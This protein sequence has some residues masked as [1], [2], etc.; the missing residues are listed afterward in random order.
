MK[1]KS[2][3]LENFAAIYV[4]LRR[5]RLKL[6]FSTFPNIIT[7]IVG[8]MGSGKT[9]ILS[10][11]HPWA[12]IGTLDE[13]NSDQLIRPE[14]DGLK[15][16]VFEDAGDIYDITHKYTWTKDHHATKSFFKFNGEELNPNGNQSSFKE[17]VTKFM[18]VD[19]SY[20]R[21][22]RIGPNVSNIIDMPWNQR[23]LY[24]ADM[25]QS[26]DIYS[27]ILA[28]VKQKMRSCDAELSVITKQMM[29]VTD[30]DID[31][32][33]AT[34]DR[35]TKDVECEEDRIV[36]ISEQIQ[37]LIATNDTMLRKHQVMSLDQ[38]KEIKDS[39]VDKRKKANDDIDEVKAKIARCDNSLNIR[40][41]MKDIGKANANI[42]NDKR[43]RLSLERQSDEYTS[44]LNSLKIKK[45]NAASDSYIKSLA[46]TYDSM[47][48][49][50]NEY[51]EHLKDY[52]YSMTSTEITT[53]MSDIQLMDQLIF[54]V[55]CC[56]H[57]IVTDIL[58]SHSD[59]VSYARNQIDKLQAKVSSIHKSIN[60]MQYISGYDVSYD[61]P[62]VT[63]PECMECPYYKTHPN[64]VKMVDGSK[65][66]A[67]IRK[68]RAEIDEI[69][70]LIDKFS[71]YPSVSTKIRKA[72]DVFNKLKGTVQKLDA[73]VQ[74]DI[75][76]I[77]SSGQNKIWYNYDKIVYALQLATEYEKRGAL[78]AKLGDIKA[79]LNKYKSLDIESIDKDIRESE[80]MILDTAQAIKELDADIDK[81]KA[82]IESL[83]NLIDDY[84]HLNDLDNQLSNLLTTEDDLVKCIKEIKEDI[85]IISDNEDTLRDLNKT[86]E[87]LKIRYA[88][89]KRTLDN[90]NIN[91]EKLVEGRKQISVLQEQK[92]LYE[93]IRDAS[94]PQSGI[95]LIYV[96]MFL[97][98]CI[99]VTNELIS[100]VLD[101]SIEILDLDLSKPD[102][103]IPYRKNDKIIDDVKSASQ[104]ERAI[105]SLA[106]SFAFMNKC[107]NMRNGGSI[108]NIL[109]L[110]EIDAPFYKDAR[111]KCLGILSQ[112]IKINNI[113]QVFFITHNNCYDGF[114]INMIATTD[115]GEDKKDIPTIRLY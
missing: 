59:A 61:L 65:M 80:A 16:I 58:G 45:Q 66:D 52:E 71:E 35:L 54:D 73:L 46:E 112:Q 76:Y 106:L 24:A 1:I 98:D 30:K 43:L 68:K 70:V 28:A 17:L 14:Y 69:N 41:I 40:D 109:L 91:I 108:Y 7:I 60:N 19:Q 22:T 103:K 8:D 85:E 67:K 86:F 63:K 89:D 93:L 4:G 26:V 11:L 25:L 107:I 64:V 114:P 111:E 27:E 23:K 102:L 83:N 81:N 75:K 87:D 97:N 110:D 2:V 13:R 5:S 72:S 6:D 88:D 39:K 9:T 47:I 56:G 3:E 113:E 99:N 78:E 21:I 51:N 42:D 101:D 48:R 95:P 77:L 100:M 115:T 36:N 37:R 44:K 29:N 79:E 33:M 84:N 57:D 49:T 105:I 96:Q 74:N 32:M 38:L 34:S 104:G 12:T 94:S 92:Y 90:L 10:Q 55:S 50:C 20:L 31:A 53:V 62:P 18:G 82:E 15:H